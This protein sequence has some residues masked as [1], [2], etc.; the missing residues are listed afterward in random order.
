[1]FR[2]YYSTTVDGKGKPFAILRQRTLVPQSCYLMMELCVKFVKIKS[3]A[4]LN[5]VL[6]RWRTDLICVICGRVKAKHCGIE[7]KRAYCML[8]ISQMTGAN[9][10]YVIDL[11][12]MRNFI[13]ISRF[14]CIGFQ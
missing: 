8:K 7:Y 3:L 1:M 11:S 6:S 5:L 4:I 2:L 14:E 13:K 9:N 10:N 12:I